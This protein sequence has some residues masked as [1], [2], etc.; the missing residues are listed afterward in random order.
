MIYVLV[1]CLLPVLK[2]YIHFL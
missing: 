1:Y 2:C